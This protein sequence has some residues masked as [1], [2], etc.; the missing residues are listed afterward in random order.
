MAKDIFKTGYRELQDHLIAISEIP[1]RLN[2]CDIV[3]KRELLEH[4][5]NETSSVIE[6]INEVMIFN[7][8]YP[9]PK[10]YINNHFGYWANNV[11]QVFTYNQ[12]QYLKKLIHNSIKTVNTPL[13]DNSK[14]LTLSE[15]K[16]FDRHIF[17]DL[18]SQQLFYYIIH[19]K[20]INSHKKMGLFF[21]WLYE[22]L[23]CSKIA[24][25]VYWNLLDQPY[26][27]KIDEGKS[28]ASFK[29]DLNNTTNKIADDLNDLKL[30]FDDIYKSG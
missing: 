9:Y 30:E 24:F 1:E 7:P 28:S 18:K 25:A 29:V 13:K 5:E 6:S 16:D 22:Y 12:L 10:E 19:R 27:I 14:D 20:E 8:N 23:D 11:S 21:N 4:I 2:R 17:R 26:K 15:N 3:L